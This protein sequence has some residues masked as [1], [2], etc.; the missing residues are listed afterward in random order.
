MLFLGNASE[1]ILT[2]KRPR[3]EVKKEMLAYD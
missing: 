3:K 2:I 1:V